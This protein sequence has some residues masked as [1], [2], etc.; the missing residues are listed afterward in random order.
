MHSPT[1]YRLRLMVDEVKKRRRDYNAPVPMVVPSGTPYRR[2]E[3]EAV[4][5]AAVEILADHERL[6]VETIAERLGWKAL[7]RVRAIIATLRETQSW[8]WILETTPGRD[9]QAPT[10][11]GRGRGGLAS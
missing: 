7:A 11:G 4:Q 1:E 5:R 6:C 2:A 10:D 9:A 3:F 8:R